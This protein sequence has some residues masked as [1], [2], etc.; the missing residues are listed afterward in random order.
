MTNNAIMNSPKTAA[1]LAG[2]MYVLLIPLGLMAMMYVPATI[3]VDGDI[4]AT[5]ANIQ[6][7]EMI[8]RLA[9]VAA[10]LTQLVNLYLVYLLYKLLSPVSKDIARAMALLIVLGLPIA[11]LSEL[12]NAAVLLTLDSPDPSTSLIS[13]FLGLH[14][15]G[16]NIAGIF[17]GLWL[18]PMGYLVFKSGFMPKI[19][20]ILLMIGCFGYLFD[21][22][23]YFMN[24][25]FEFS[26]AEFLFF[27]E[28]AMAFWLLFMGV[29]TEKW[30]QKRLEAQG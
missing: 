16:I 6:A 2:L 9:S 19:V 25:D 7:N 5:I 27:G 12:N 17:W 22:F 8:F 14:E 18:F 3:L 21:S 10:Y 11:W 23:I 20:G 29:N 30:Q 15:Y 13:M 1:R 24:P 4:A 28:M 26:F